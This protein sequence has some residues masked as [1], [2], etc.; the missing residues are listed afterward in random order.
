M[1]YNNECVKPRG[2]GVTLDL[3]TYANMLLTSKEQYESS[4]SNY[5]RRY[6][7]Y[8]LYSFK[9]YLIFEQDKRFFTKKTKNVSWQPLLEPKYCFCSSCKLQAKFPE[10]VILCLY[11]FIFYVYKNINKQGL[12]KII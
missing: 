11:L 1:Q 8:L 12:D 2:G 6:L 7:E 9:P 5:A 10:S 4:Q 3:N